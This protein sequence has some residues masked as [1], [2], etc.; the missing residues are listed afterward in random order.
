MSAGTG[1]P[2]S[3]T[4]C[5]GALQHHRG[6]LSVSRVGGAGAAVWEAEG[7]RSVSL[8]HTAG[9]DM[10]QHVELAFLREE[11]DSGLGGSLLN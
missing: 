4:A 3:Y 1:V 2:L 5:T 9:D 8:K 6:I 7:I 11:G 10:V